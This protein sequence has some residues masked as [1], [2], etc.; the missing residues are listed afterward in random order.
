MAKLKINVPASLKL[1]VEKQL[2]DIVKDPKI[3]DEVKDFTVKVI[4]DEARFGRSMEGTKSRSRNLPKL[5]KGYVKA[6]QRGYYKDTDPEFFVKNS[7]R[8]NLTLTGQFLKSIFGQ[9]L[10]SGR[11]V[12]SIAVYPRG[13]RK[14]GNKNIEIIRWL[15]E[16][17]KRYE[18]FSLNDK[19][20]K[21]ISK[22]VQ[23]G[24]RRK[25]RNRR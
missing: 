2:Q 12:G 23:R 8:S 22:I 13:R 17:D 11:G 19:A 20:I 16:L 7:T 25:L 18:I 1:K 21:E 10:L 15:T 4:V 5:S 14:D 3:L 9:R 24:L 6:R